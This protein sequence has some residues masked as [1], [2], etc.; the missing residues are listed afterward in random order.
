MLGRRIVRATDQSLDPLVTGNRYLLF[1]EFIPD[2]G[3]YKAFNSKGSF[4][5]DGDKAVKLTHEDLP[6]EMET[7]AGALSLVA[8]IRS[9]I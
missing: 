1:L 5:L 3:A 2:T 9:A 4:L 6:Y 8:R 7:E